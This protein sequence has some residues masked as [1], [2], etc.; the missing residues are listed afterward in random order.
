MELNWVFHAASLVININKQKLKSLK[1]KV[2]V[3]HILENEKIVLLN[4]QGSVPHN[5]FKYV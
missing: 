4:E 3:S 1:R 5:S 2:D